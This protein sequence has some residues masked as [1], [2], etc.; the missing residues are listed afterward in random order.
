Q[1]S[2]L[3][4]QDV[5]WFLGR[6]G[7][8]EKS[9]QRANDQIERTMKTN[10]SAIFVISA[11]CTLCFCGESSAAIDPQHQSPYHLRVVLSIAEPRML[12]SQFQKQLETDIRDQLQLSFGKLVQVE[13][14]RAH[15]RL[16]DIRLKGL[17]AVLDGWDEV[18]STRTQFVLIDFGD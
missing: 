6:S 10:H 11:L 15:P 16:N 18:S 7:N 1:E 12:T 2:G 3:R 8:A 5:S 4:C 14:V 9:T 13:V 17:Q